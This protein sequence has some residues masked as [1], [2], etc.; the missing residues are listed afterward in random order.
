MFIAGSQ[1]LGNRQSLNLQGAEWN[2]VAS[3][4]FI[5]NAAEFSC[6]KTHGHSIAVIPAL[7][8]SALMCVDKE[9]TEEVFRNVNSSVDSFMIK[10]WPFGWG[11]QGVR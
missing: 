3:V 10:T 2:T 5:S 1:S 4:T 8:L 6:N 7:N 11:K 9:C